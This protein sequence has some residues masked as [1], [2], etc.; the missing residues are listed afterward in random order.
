MQR[1]SSLCRCVPF[2]GIQCE[3]SLRFFASRV[4]GD[5]SYHASYPCVRQRV[6]RARQRG[7]AARRAVPSPGIPQDSRTARAA[8]GL[9]S[10]E[11]LVTST[12]G[13]TC[14]L[15]YVAVERGRHC[16]PP[17]ISDNRPRGG[18]ALAQVGSFRPGVSCYP[19][20]FGG[21]TPRGEGSYF[22]ASFA[23]AAAY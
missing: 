11:S 21:A 15:V 18:M 4:C 22:S 6:P 13:N 12:S 2:F 1:C 17:Q 14:W 16:L 8:I 10:A 3:S 5:P 19:P 7:H 23:A 9:Y 20:S